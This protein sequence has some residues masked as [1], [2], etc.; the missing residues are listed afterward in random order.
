MENQKKKKVK[1]FYN[2]DV[3]D[4]YPMGC[5]FWTPTEI[6]K[7]PKLSK[8]SDKHL[9]PVHTL[10]DVFAG[11]N[12]P[13]AIDVNKNKADLCVSFRGKNTCFNLLARN[14]DVLDVWFYGIRYVIQ[15]F[16]KKTAS[17][18]VKDY[19]NVKSDVV[20]KNPAT[21]AVNAMLRGCIMTI[22]SG[23]ILM[24]KRKFV[25]YTREG[26]KYGTI[27]WSASGRVKKPKTGYLFAFFERY[28]HGQKTLHV[29]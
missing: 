10:T 8:L 18:E 27:Y 13:H 15:S 9:L 26:G 20:W 11:S 5:L 22:Y 19:E 14:N 4:E 7:I 23:M 12:C 29:A 17:V 24:K 6:T 28:L 16:A 21:K 1:L 2:H 25:F 3:T